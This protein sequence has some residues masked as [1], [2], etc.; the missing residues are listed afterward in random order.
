MK[1]WYADF[2]TS[3]SIC[4]RTAK[5]ALPLVLP[6][7]CSSPMKS[8]AADAL[9]LK[10]T[11]A[12]LERNRINSYYLTTATEVGKKPARSIA[13]NSGWDGCWNQSYSRVKG[14]VLRNIME[15]TKRMYVACDHFQARNCSNGRAALYSQL[16]GAEPF[17][18]RRQPLRF[19]R[20]FPTFYRI[21]RF[22]AVFT[23]APPLVTI[24]SQNNPVNDTPSYF[25]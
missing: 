11:I 17:L 12:W 18:R 22:N 5:A 15:H 8:I 10:Q 2:A 21:W 1:V 6:N 7:A 19:L 13:R 9:I 3:Q 24:L 23:R 25:S 4:E 14:E 20:I 16:C